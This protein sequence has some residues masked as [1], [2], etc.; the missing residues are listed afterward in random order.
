MS[1]AQTPHPDTKDLA[2]LAGE[3]LGR[4]KTQRILDH[5]KECPDCAERLLEIVRTLPPSER[6]PPSRWT[7]ISIVLFAVALIV[8]VA[9]MIGLLRSIS[10]PSPFVGEAPAP[11]LAETLVAESPATWF[12][13]A[14]GYA[15]V[16][17]DQRWMLRSGRLGVRLFDMQ[18]LEED[19]D[20]LRSGF[21][22]V[23]AATFDGRGR[24]ARYANRRRDLGWFVEDPDADRP[25][26]TSLPLNSIPAWSAENA[27]VMWTRP[28]RTRL[29]LGAPP[30]D[31]GFDVA[32]QI[33][34]VTWSPAG[35]V[36]F[37]LVVD[38]AG[39]GSL[40]RLRTDGSEPEPVRGSLDVS[41]GPNGV[42]AARGG[43]SVY[44]ALASDRAPD[45]ESRHQPG[46]DRDLD[47]YEID[48]FSGEIRAVVTT[49]GDDFWP[50]VAGGYLYWTHN[51][52]DESVV[53]LP[54][55]V[56]GGEIITVAGPGGSHPGAQLPSWSPDGARL[57]F[58]HGG[59]RIADWGLNLDA[60][61]VGI[62]PDGSITTPAEPLVSGYHEDFT[63][64]WSPDGRWLA[65]HSHR[66]QEPVVYYAGPGVADDVFLRR[67]GDPEAE[68]IRL[69]DFGWE[70]GD[71]DWSPDGRRLVFDSWERG[72]VPNVSRPWIA[73]I[74]PETGSLLGVEPLPLPDGVEGSVSAVF[75]PV[76]D[77]LVL[78]ERLDPTRQALWI[79]TPDGDAATRIVEF[80][81]LTYGGADWMPDGSEIVYAA[82][83]G[84]RMQLFLIPRDGGEPRQ[85]TDD[86]ANL[87]HPA[88]SPD[89]RWIAATRM[90]R[91][92][93][94]R[95]LPIY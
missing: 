32:G 21:Q 57:A 71:P 12:E 4:K 29:S 75:S 30:N 92:K 1:S 15:V 83:V 77:E 3:R 93:E 41:T 9:T 50:S 19:R 40:L 17:S 62:G 51:E 53:L 85:L 68:E 34:G 20:R 52:F 64:R 72:G 35:D 60:A 76:A 46:L 44:V 63:P 23:M 74:D 66:P 95:R 56:R 8:T 94:I 55:D 81:S 2:N 31:R 80:D 6:R 69:T 7:W 48:V 43:A 37:A 22:G 78:I 33:L 13:D 14:F 16:S 54:L 10:R 28:P 82:L 18:T 39:V 70:V 88:V 58:T 26:L 24:V 59:W 45:P 11:D 73:T 61:V 65:F 86:P 47:I 27:E 84:D 38:N 90:V 87:L 91:R 25:E 49:P 36:A 5:C 79:T 89:G 67:A 42:A